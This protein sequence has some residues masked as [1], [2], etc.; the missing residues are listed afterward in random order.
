MTAKTRA[1]EGLIG[2]VIGGGAGAAGGAL[3]YE[4]RNPREWLDEYGNVKDRPL[5]PHEK[6]ERLNRAAVAA[7]LGAAGGAGA[8]LGASHLIGS[9]MRAGE[10]EA[11]EKVIGDVLAPLHSIIDDARSERSAVLAKTRK[12]TA[13]FLRGEEL[14]NTVRTG[15]TVLAEQKKALRKLVDTAAGNRSKLLFHGA[16]K[17]K[18]VPEG[19]ASGFDWSQTTHEGLAGKHLDAL[20]QSAGEPKLTLSNAYKVFHTI[21]QKAMTKTSEASFLRELSLIQETC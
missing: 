3:S 18:D 2:A 14:K 4:T 1:I 17:P 9:R 21:V 10:Q 11:S 7:I 6:K 16:Y 15:E 12:T 5:L 19:V 13:D 8:T 20:A